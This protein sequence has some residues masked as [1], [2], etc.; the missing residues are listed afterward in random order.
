MAALLTLLAVLSTYWRLHF[1]LGFINSTIKFCPGIHDTVPCLCL[2]WLFVLRSQ[3]LF[4]VSLL[5]LFGM[6]Q[7]EY[8][9]SLTIKAARCRCKDLSYYKYC[10]TTTQSTGT[11]GISVLIGYAAAGR[12]ES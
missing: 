2:L 8:A 11:G 1:K 12:L 4:Q 5:G 6:E 7:T 9:L 3:C 10:T